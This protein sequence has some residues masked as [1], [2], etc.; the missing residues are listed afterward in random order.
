MSSI[1]DNSEL[2]IHSNTSQISS[3][4]R[5]K[6]YDIDK[7]LRLPLPNEPKYDKKKLK[8]R[9]CAQADCLYSS[10]VL[11]NVRKHLEN[12]HGIEVNP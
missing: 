7:Y 9:Y 10:G 11:I 5:T 6:L 2:Q 1:Q 8:L 4:S 3:K 12:S